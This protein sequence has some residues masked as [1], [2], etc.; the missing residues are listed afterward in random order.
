[1]N[2]L[3]YVIQRLV[4]VVFT[5]LIITTLVF[6]VLYSMPGDFISGPGITP[7]VYEAIATKFHLNEPMPVQYMYFLK[8]YLNLDFGYSWVIRTN[9]PV[10]AL[11]QE[12]LPI[13]IQLNL[14]A[15]LFTFPMG[16]L[17]GITMAIKKGKIYDNVMS[18][19]VILFISAP[20]FVIAALLQFFLAYKFGWF[21]KTLAPI[22][23]L[24]PEKF[25]S[26]IL[27]IL[28]LSFSNIASI[29]RMLRAELSEVLTSDFM[30]L[31]KSK[32]LSFRQSIVRHGLRNACV[33]MA[34]QFFYLFTYLLAG[35]I[36]IENIF[37]VPGLS[38]ILI[39]AINA[40]DHMLSM[41]VV[42]FY[43]IIGLVMA[44]AAD[45]SYGVLDPRIRVGGR[46][47]GS[48]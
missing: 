37:G 12:R 34:A 8:N 39:S 20:S 41:G 40:K 29:S 19:L 10:A 33:P 35:S 38:Y 5:F 16:L 24:T 15:A 42:F 36:V 43:V 26:M 31:A 18:S 45:L 30:L 4:G 44:I 6:F 47:D 9:M 23:E 3:K 48:R 32:G 2:L 13:T 1:M 21:P 46:K 28:A 27:P 22:K 14:F 17:F 11:I 7:A 25:H